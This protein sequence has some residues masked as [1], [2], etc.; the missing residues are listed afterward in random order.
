MDTRVDERPKTF[1][2]AF[3]FVSSRSVSSVVAMVAVVVTE[4]VEVLGMGC[5]VS[6]MGGKGMPAQIDALP[7]VE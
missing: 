4:D 6:G 3:P 5:G 1:F 2:R 7:R